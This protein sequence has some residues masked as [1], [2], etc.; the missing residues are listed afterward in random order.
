[1]SPLTTPTAEASEVLSRK[2]STYKL[3][4]ED[5]GVKLGRATFERKTVFQK[6]KVGATTPFD[7]RYLVLSSVYPSDVSFFV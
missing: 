5:A 4:Q 2:H 1:M 7:W 6:G 3:P